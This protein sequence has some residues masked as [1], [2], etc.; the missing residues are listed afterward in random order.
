MLYPAELRERVIVFSCLIR[1]MQVTGMIPTATTEVYQGARTQ[2]LCDP[3]GNLY[4]RG[5]FIA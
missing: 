5:Q 2:S 4:N 3:W 1:L